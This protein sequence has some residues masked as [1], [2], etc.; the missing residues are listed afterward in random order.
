MRGAGK[1]KAKARADA[2]ASGALPKRKHLNYDIHDFI[3]MP[4][5]TLFI[6]HANPENNY[7]ASWLASKLKL[8]GY[9]VWVDV[10]DIKPGQYFNRDFER[11]IKE[12]AI[13]FLA[14]V[15]EQY[16]TKAKLDDTGVMNEI[17]CARTVEKIEGFVIPLRYDNSEF[18]DF[19]PGLIGRQAI[20]FTNNWAEG[21]HELTKYLEEL[22]ISKNQKKE[23]V[24]QFWHEAQKIK[25]TPI[26]QP[27]K[28]FTNW[29][30]SYLPEHIYLHKPVDFDEQKVKT[31]PFTK[32]SEG[33]RI[34]TFTDAETLEYILPLET[35]VKLRTLDLCQISPIRFE[36][37]FE[38]QEPNKKLVKLMNRSF[39][40]HLV[41][42]HMRIYLQANKK[43]VFFFPF[44]EANTKSVNL[45]QLGRARRAI[46]GKTSEFIWY[47]GISFSASLLPAPCFKIFY[48]LV[49]TD[50]Q[51]NLLD[52]DDQHELRRSLP[53][54]WFNRK[55]LE[56]LLA[57]MLKISQ[58]DPDKEIKIEVAK[59]KLMSIDVL[60]IQIVSEIGYNEPSGETQT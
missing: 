39:R 34:I 12:E 44:N 58:F 4:R 49:F 55:W 13:R 53:S 37:G 27:E 43:E 38:L 41:G 46:I 45:K 17:L 35:S 7:F 33:N 29:F 31:L 20:S 51:G 25:S 28:Y 10:S 21:L 24:L 14:V 50:N 5:E 60:P 54:D 2:R 1:A 15:S 3:R 36:D 9:K 6:S 57:M 18:S 59:R 56:T 8:L 47:F 16:I 40:N 26:R 48:H 11:I 32:I 23:N 42:R 52:A 22:N 19:G 30:T